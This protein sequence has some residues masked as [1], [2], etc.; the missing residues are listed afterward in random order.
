MSAL[1]MAGIAGGSYLIGAGY[2][3]RRLC[4][5][6]DNYHL[7]AICDFGVNSEALEPDRLIKLGDYVLLAGAVLV[8]TSV[9]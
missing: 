3:V 6:R 4:I 2:F 1:Q 7:P 8:F 5:S 9:F